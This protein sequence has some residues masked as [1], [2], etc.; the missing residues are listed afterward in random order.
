MEFSHILDPRREEYKQKIAS[1]E[2]EIK[3][4]REKL[5]RYNKL[6]GEVNGKILA[7]LRK[8]LSDIGE[9][10][11]NVSK[12]LVGNVSNQEQKNISRCKENIIEIISDINVIISGIDKK[13]KKLN[14]K[15]ARLEKEIRDTRSKLLLLG[16]ESSFWN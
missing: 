10:K 5:D 12:F 4:T 11:Q 8:S 6:K 9:I 13:I 1:A 16:E 7:N 3:K 14:E 15:I 2:A